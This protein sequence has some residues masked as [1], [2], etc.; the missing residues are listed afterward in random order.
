M[1][2]KTNKLI[3]VG[4]I[5]CLSAGA[6]AKDLYIKEASDWGGAHPN[7][8]ASN[9]IDGSTD[10]SSRWAAEVGGEPV[11]LVLDLGSLQYVQDVAIAWGKGDVESYKFEI[12]A[13]AD[14]NS[15]D[16]TKVYNGNSSGS[17]TDFENYDISDIEARWIRVK[18]FSN[19]AGSEWTNITEVK[20]SGD[21]ASEPGFDLDPTLPPSGNFDV[22][23]WYLSIPVDE[24]DGYAT[25]VKEKVLTSGYES[26]YFYTGSDGG[27]VFYTPVGGVVTSNNTKYVRT[28]LREMLR[29]GDTSITTS[30]KANNWAFSSIPLSEQQYFGGIDG[31]LKATLAVNHVTTTT[32]NLQQVGRLVVGQIHAKS[33]EPIRLYY[34]KLPNNEKGALY[35]AHETSKSAGG[36]ETWYNLLGNMVTSDGSLNDTSSPKD[37]LLLD[38]PFSYSIVVNG[39]QLVVTISQ[40]GHELT[41]KEVDM[42]KSGYD[43]PD[44]YMYFKAGIY[45]QDNSSDDHDYAQVTFYELDNSH[46]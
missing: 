35:F 38:E 4:I 14:E 15:S 9:A 12:R 36:D 18:V 7:Y 33:N 41:A 11:N 24:G 16:W 20:I 1:T 2:L 30:S 43:D 19:S 17:T 40:N 39:D 46:K 3:S 45:L 42:S 32:S 23:D 31:T 6:M 5:C 44:N 21:G 27:L 8:P 25:D 34:H 28:E 22:E 10:W 29:R 13:L 26:D 37:G